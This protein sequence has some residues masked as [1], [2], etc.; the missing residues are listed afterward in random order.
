MPLYLE[1]FQSTPAACPA[2]WTEVDYQPLEI[3]LGYYT[4]RRSC[5]AP[6]STCSVLYL[7][8]FNG[9]TPATCPAGWVQA[10]AQNL[11]I[12]LGYYTY[13]RSCIKC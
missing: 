12:V 9:N 6:S 1:A 2:T 11:E 13:R 4:N 3:V 5:V 8:G 10:D 7:D